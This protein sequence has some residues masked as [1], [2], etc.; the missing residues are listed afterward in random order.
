MSLIGNSI[1][2]S[3]TISVRAGADIGAG[4]GLAVK[5]DKS[6]NA[7]PC[8]AAGESALGILLMQQGETKSGEDMSVQIKDAGTAVSGG[9][10]ACGDMVSAGADGRIIKAQSGHFILGVALGAC[11]SAG[12]HIPVQIAKCGYMP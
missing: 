8:S 7:V 12:A 11:S 1:N 2:Q 3:A 9:A 5:F 6:G 4:A 10:I